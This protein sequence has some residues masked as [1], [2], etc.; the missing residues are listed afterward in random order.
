MRANLRHEPGP[1]GRQG[2]GIKLLGRIGG[3]VQA[4]F[5]IGMK[6]DIYEDD[7]GAEVAEFGGETGGVGDDAGTGVRGEGPADDS[8][9]EVNQHEGGLSGVDGE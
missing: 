6:G 4:V 2:G 9:L 5:G 3:S 8:V 7:S 1:V